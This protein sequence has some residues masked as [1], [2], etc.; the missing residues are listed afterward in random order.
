MARETITNS[1]VASLESQIVTIGSDS[2]E[3]AIPYGF[4][5]QRPNVP[6]NLNFLNLLSN[7]FNVVATMAVIRAD[8]KYSPQSA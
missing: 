5:G 8:E 2:S 4:G 7:P 1:S 3:P 6:P